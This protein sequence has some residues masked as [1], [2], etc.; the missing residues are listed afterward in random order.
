[1]VDSIPAGPGKWV[2]GGLERMQPCKPKL[3]QFFGIDSISFFL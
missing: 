3:L 1:M 2:T